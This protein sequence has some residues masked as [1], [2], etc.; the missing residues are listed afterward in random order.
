M[1]PVNDI[2]AN[3]ELFLP[4]KAAAHAVIPLNTTYSHLSPLLMN[5]I[6]RKVLMQLDVVKILDLD[7]SAKIKGLSKHIHLDNPFSAVNI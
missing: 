1:L 4:L 6:T 2:Y 3:I 7:F 5:Y